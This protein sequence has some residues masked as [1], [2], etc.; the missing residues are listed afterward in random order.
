MFVSKARSQTLSEASKRYIRKEASGFTLTNV[1]Q[2]WKGLS[3]IN[4]PAYRNHSKVTKKK[5]KKSFLNA[6][7]R[8]YPTG[9]N[10]KNTPL[11]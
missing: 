9:E 11:G 1:R 7:P 8:A 6:A 10:L 2:S 4:T 3:R 5:R